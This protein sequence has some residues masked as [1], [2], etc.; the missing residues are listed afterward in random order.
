MAS[1]GKIVKQGANG[2]FKRWNGLKRDEGKLRIL[3]HV[4]RGGNLDDHQWKEIKDFFLND[5]NE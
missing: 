3:Q 5:Q 2:D 4:L 1:Q